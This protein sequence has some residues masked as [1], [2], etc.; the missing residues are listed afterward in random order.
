MHLRC[1]AILS[2]SVVVLL[3]FTVTAV[4]APSANA[5]LRAADSALQVPQ[6]HASALTVVAGALARPSHQLLASSTTTKRTTYVYVTK[7]GTKY[8]R[9]GCRYLTQSKTKVALAWAKSHGYKR[10]SV[11]KPPK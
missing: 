10:C 3:L 7:T 5:G 9:K 4:A 8:H 1:R 11:C 6:S 2:L